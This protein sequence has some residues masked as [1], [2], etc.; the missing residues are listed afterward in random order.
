MSDLAS[1]LRSCYS[2]LTAAHETMERIWK[3]EQRLDDREW[4]SIKPIHADAL[5]KAAEALDE[6]DRTKFDAEEPLKIKRW[7]LTGEFGGGSE[8]P[9]TDTNEI[10]G[11]AGDLLDS[12]EA[13]GIFGSA[14]FEGEN[15]KYYVMVVAGSLGEANPSYV[16]DVLAE[17]AI[18]DDDEEAAG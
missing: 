7:I 9:P 17:Q 15:G 13:H 6:H 18:A 14:L 16:E 4:D 8:G 11:I 3:G 2:A 1:A 12:C 10:Y 5:Q